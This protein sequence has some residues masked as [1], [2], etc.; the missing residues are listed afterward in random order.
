VSIIGSKITRGGREWQVAS[1]VRAG[2]ALRIIFK[3]VDDPECRILTQ[4]DEGVVPTR[5]AELSAAL[6]APTARWF[7]DQ[8]GELWKVQIRGASG[9]GTPLGGWMV[10]VSDRGGIRARLRREG[11]SGIGSMTDDELTKLLFEARR[12]PA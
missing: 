12:T 3:A 9:M 6:A 7:R 11:L 4:A 1:T 8:N 10:F 5:A 2:S